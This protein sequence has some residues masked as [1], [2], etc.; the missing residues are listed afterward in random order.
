MKS[1]CFIWHEFV[2]KIVIHAAT[3]PRSK[4]NRT[5]QVDIYYKGI[6]ILEISKVFDTQHK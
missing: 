4:A 2:E 6:G 1:I 5:Q 3:D